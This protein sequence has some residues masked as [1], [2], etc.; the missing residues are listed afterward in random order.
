METYF[1]FSD[2]VKLPRGW[3]ASRKGAI[4]YREQIEELLKNSNG[5]VY[6]DLKD[7]EGICGTSADEIF[8]VLV[9]KFGFEFLI[10]RIRLINGSKRVVTNI[11]EAMEYRSIKKTPN[12][13]S[14]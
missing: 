3:L 4:P 5:Y 10:N 12:W 2:T 13:V 11:A 14:Y 9:M 6:I 7:V 8:G 1:T